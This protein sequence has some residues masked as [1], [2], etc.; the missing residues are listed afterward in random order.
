MTMPI[1]IISTIA[2]P[3]Q[4]PERLRKVI[5]TV[6]P[7]RITVIPTAITATSIRR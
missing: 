2:R 5:F 6:T 4:L 7:I 3:E 1:A